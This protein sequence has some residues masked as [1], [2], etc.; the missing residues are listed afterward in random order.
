MYAPP[1]QEFLSFLL[2]VVFPGSQQCLAHSRSSVTIWR[3][4]AMVLVKHQAHTKTSGNSKH[5]VNTC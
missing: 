1:R 4:N 2:A 5:M 3:K